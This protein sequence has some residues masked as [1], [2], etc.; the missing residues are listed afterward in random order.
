MKLPRQFC[1]DFRA[2]A[3]RL[4][5]GDRRSGQASSADTRQLAT[6]MR[7]FVERW[8]G[9]LGS[10]QMDESLRELLEVAKEFEQVLGT[11]EKAIVSSRSVRS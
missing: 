10:P 2:I 5:S 3:Q 8:Q 11:A 6:D 9:R 1:R 4:R 7:D